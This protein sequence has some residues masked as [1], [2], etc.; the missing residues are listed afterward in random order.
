MPTLWP[1]TCPHWLPLTV[2]QFKFQL[3]GEAVTD[4][5]ISALS[6]PQPFPVYLWNTIHF[7]FFVLRIIFTSLLS[8]FSSFNVR[9]RRDL[10]SFPYIES[11]AGHIVGIPQIFVELRIESIS[12]WPYRNETTR[13]LKKRSK[14]AVTIRFYTCEISFKGKVR[15]FTNDKHF[16]NG[17]T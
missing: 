1:S 8:A 15:G 10:S 5:P 9:S 4:H 3:L 6:Q 14:D 17:V 7:N 12:P 11:S 13:Y 2:S 16:Q